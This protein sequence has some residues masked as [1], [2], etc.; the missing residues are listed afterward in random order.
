MANPPPDEPASPVLS[1]LCEPVA[2]DAAEQFAAA[3]QHVDQ[4]RTL[5]GSLAQLWNQS[6]S[7][8]ADAHLISRP[9]GTGEIVVDLD[10][11]QPTHQALN[12]TARDVGVELRRALDAGV[13]ALAQLVS[14]V[15]VPPD[16]AVVRFPLADTLD[17]FL[18]AHNEGAMDG[19]RPDQVEFVEALQPFRL[20]SPYGA[21]EVLDFLRRLTEQP[22]GSDVVMAWTHLAR[23][24]VTVEP[25][26]HV[27]IVDIEPDG[28]IT[29]SKRIA[30]FRVT[31][32]GDLCLWDRPVIYGNPN[33][34][35][36]LMAAVGPA[37]RTP[38]DTFSHRSQVMVSTVTL[39]LE[40]FERSV[41]LRQGVVDS[42]DPVAR[43]A[44]GRP[45]G[46]NWAPLLS[47][48][49]RADEAIEAVR[50]SEV[51]LASITDDQELTLVVATGVETYLRRVAAAT[52]L[53]PRLPPGIAAEEATATAAAQWGLPDFVFPPVKRQVG[54]GS[55]EI[56]DGIVLVGHHG[57]I[58]QVK[59]RANVT[60]KPER[61]ASWIHKKAEEG[62][63]QAAGTLRQLRLEPAQLTNQRGREFT[64]DGNTVAW[65]AVVIIDHSDPP[66]EVQLPGNYR[67]LPTLTL[68]RRDWEFL[69]EQLGSTA[70]VV[71]Y[72]HRVAG[73]TCTL[74]NEPAAYYELAGKDA[75]APQQPP[76]NDW[77]AQAGVVIQA[78]PILPR[79]PAA[80]T[81]GQSHGHTMF[82]ILLEDLSAARFDDEVGRLMLLS[83]L[84]QTPVAY[85]AE[86][87]DRLLQLLHEA[88]QTE[89]GTFS[90][91]FRWILD[92]QRPH[93]AGFGVFNQLS[94]WHNE[95]F[96][97]KLLLQHHRM[98]LHDWDEEEDASTVGVL[99]TPNY[100]RRDRLWDSTVM[101]VFGPSSLDAEDMAVHE[102]FWSQPQ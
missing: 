60:D 28:P 99:L 11:D 21:S 3:W 68:L 29:V 40:A 35:F 66:R 75:E 81:I 47:D 67:G 77:A 36:D 92:T 98:T 94:R 37:P 55:R 50:Q 9:S 19:I 48:Q 53:D 95:A 45:A 54:S 57:L 41:G 93:Q 43:V 86:V 85:Q 20:S 78:R 71:A 101:A 49:E 24:E 96:R 25:P 90:S 76:R 58:L 10:F 14:G 91:G 70:A 34:A 8:A 79:T 18:A 16:P 2:T 51:G 32:P 44:A 27:E 74:G 4:A 33:V 80:A 83:L 46:P 59:S 7:A 89:I 87:G 38:D 12:G 5:L 73:D 84:D 30:T 102:A 39:I 69:F 31:H 88:K 82:R 42:W 1:E 52:A 22:V 56:S 62:A 26:S 23:P 13:V 15:L 65:A 72:V 6:S 100:G 64:I 63:R 97:S 61:E 17:A